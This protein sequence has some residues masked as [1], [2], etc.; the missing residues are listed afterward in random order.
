MILDIFLSTLY[1]VLSTIDSMEIKIVTSEDGSHTLFI[2]SMNETYHSLHGALQESEHV[3]ITHGLKEIANTKEE[4]NIFEVGFGTGLNAL[5]TLKFCLEH[6]KKVNY[7]TLEPFPI[8]QELV[9]G[10]NYSA[11]LKDDRLTAA[12]AGMHQQSF[13]TAVC[14]EQI[15]SFTK[16]NQKLEDFTAGIPLMEVIYYDAFAPSKQPEVWAMSNIQKVYD[17]LFEY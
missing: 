14:Y 11:L 13:N 5:L 16:F 6:H 9:E 3:F 8:S 1:P 10:I 7:Y 12:Y 4:I 17:L 15:F 2:P